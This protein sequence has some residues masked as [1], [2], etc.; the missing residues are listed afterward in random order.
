MD[1][2]EEAINDLLDDLNLAYE[3]DDDDEPI[4]AYE[5]DYDEGSEDEM[6]WYYDP[7][8]V[9][10]EFDQYGNELTNPGPSDELLAFGQLRNLGEPDEMQ[11]DNNN[12]NKNERTYLSTIQEDEEDEEEDDEAEDQRNKD[13]TD[14]FMYRGAGRT[15]GRGR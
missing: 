13:K 14:M 10:I 5:N 9:P 11:A 6:D 7:D 12:N 1:I 15:R 4:Y 3:S 8:A 2:N